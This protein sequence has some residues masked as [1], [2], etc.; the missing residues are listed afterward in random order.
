ML[1]HLG[2]RWAAACASPAAFRF[3]APV[4]WPSACRRVDYP[5]MGLSAATA[6]IVWPRAG[7]P[8]LCYFRANRQGV[9]AASPQSCFCRA[10]ATG[11]E[12][13]AAGADARSE[14]RHTHLTL[15]NE[16]ARR[17]CDAVFAH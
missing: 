7:K 5:A 1:V 3:V 14:H 2:P 4:G 16:L 17:G 11:T 6:R 10:A 15:M 8:S 13:G 12:T 9:I